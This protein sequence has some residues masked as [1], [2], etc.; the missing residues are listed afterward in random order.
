[1]NGQSTEHVESEAEEDG[2][3][4]LPDRLVTELTAHRT[5]A[6][7]DAVAGDFD[8][9]LLAVLHVLTLNVFYRFAS[10]ACLEISVKSVSFGVQSPGLKETASAKAI[11]AKH[12]AWR[13]QLPENPEHLWAALVGFD[14]D[15]RQA[16][17]AHCASLTINAV[18][19]SWNRNNERRTH[20]DAL[21][22]T[23]NLDMAAAGWT[24]TVDNYLGRV[25]K[26]RILEA[27]REAKGKCAAQLIDHL[28]KSDMANEAERLL[29]GSGWLP[30]P[31]RTPL[32]EEIS[33]AAADGDALP[34][35]L[36]QNHE[37]AASEP[38]VA[39]E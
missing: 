18:H 3:R 8:I 33:S 4:P 23:V 35:F 7:R 29:A 26:A 31:L 21:A 28:K 20:A 5:L 30:E 38:L 13:K 6:L 2:L 24:P 27:V 17:F 39:A 34:A 36:S 1:V 22:A 19:E 32:F 25:S 12:D 16:L 11:E 37:G 15:S 10:G 9:A 14:A